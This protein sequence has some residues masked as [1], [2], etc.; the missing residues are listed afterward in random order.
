MRLVEETWSLDRL[1]ED[2]IRSQ[3]ER[4]LIDSALSKW[5]EEIWDFVPRPLTQNTNYVRRGDA[6]P[7]VERR[8]YLQYPSSEK[9]K[10]AR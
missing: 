10:L 1:A 4:K 5:R 7:N 2:V 8:G 6:F 9:G 3:T